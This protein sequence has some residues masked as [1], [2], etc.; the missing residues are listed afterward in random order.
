MKLIFSNTGRILRYLNILLLV[1]LIPI[2]AQGETVEAVRIFGEPSYSLNLRMDVFT[3][4][5]GH[6]TLDDIQQ[7][8][9]QKQFVRNNEP[10]INLGMTDNQHWIRFRLSNPGI[11]ESTNAIETWYLEIGR[12]LLDVAVLYTPLTDGGY[13]ATT[14]DLSVPFSKRDIRHVNSVFPVSMTIGDEG[15][16]YLKVKH[17]TILMLPLTLWTPEA[18]VKKVATEEFYYGAYFGVLIALI[19]FNSFIYLQSMDKA[20]L[21]YIFYIICL[22]WFQLIEVGHGLIHS[23]L[24]FVLEKGHVVI[25]IW[26]ATGFAILF[27]REY[28]LTKNNNPIISNVINVILWIILSSILISGITGRYIAIYWVSIFSVVFLLFILISS[29]L[30]LLNGNQNAR[31]FLLG[32]VCNTTGFIIYSLVAN[33]MIVVNLF[34]VHFVEVGILFELTFF[35]LAMADKINRSRKLILALNNESIARM[36]SYTAIF[37][38][39]QHG[40]YQMNLEGNI[41]EVNAA[42]ATTLGYPSVNAVLSNKQAVFRQL[43]SGSIN[44]MQCLMSNK[45]TSQEF[46]TLLEDGYTQR[47]FLHTSRR[48]NGSNT[49]S[50]GYIDGNIIDITEEKQ[51][52]LSKQRELQERVEKELAVIASSLKSQF[53]SVMSTHIRVPLTAIVG[54]SEL[55]KDGDVSQQEKTFYTDII[56]KNS[57]RLLSLINDILDY[58]KITAGK[59]DIECIPVNL[60]ILIEEIATENRK[61]AI[62]KSINFVVDYEYPIPE[63]FMTDATRIRQGLKILCENALKFT[64]N[65]G[66]T[67]KISYIN[68][69]LTFLVSDTGKGIKNHRV[70]SLLN[71]DALVGRG[72]FGLAILKSFV[73][74]MGGALTFTSEQNKGSDFTFSVPAESQKKL[75]KEQIQPSEVES[76]KPPTPSSIPKLVGTVLV[77]EDNLVN[78]K[79]ITKVIEKT[80]VTVIVVEDGVE[81]CEYCDTHN[82]NATL[83]DLVVMDINMPRRNGLEATEYLRHK[84]YDIPIYALTAETAKSEINK[85]MDA[86][87]DGFLSKPLEKKKLYAILT[88]ILSDGIST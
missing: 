3:D 46:Y 36:E 88:L 40:K 2:D 56:L 62:S 42:A 63:V 34:T 67:L 60:R 20:Y 71:Q 55:L 41:L 32:W 12:A 10:I 79:I 69:T 86:G 54:Y 57:Q 19:A 28:L 16:Y 25:S 68:K 37:N 80:G 83:P 17:A 43:Y 53:L 81:A 31:Y 11:K 50:I 66:V 44:T 61:K 30:L 76:L 39:C 38:N 74:Q 45:V 14:S 1:I 51:R 59:L 33:E 9:Y 5:T 49:G 26:G 8:Q 52:D 18:F 58:S 87:C 65:G 78:Q 82:V 24:A 47:W 75:M 72:S 73:S 29:F 13:T 7:L 64:H 22:G 15:V 6:L 70:N 27:F 23:D 48:I 77:A 85:A 21:Y 84:K 35:S 4:V